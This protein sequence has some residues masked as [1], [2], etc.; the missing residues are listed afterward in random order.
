M[1]YVVFYCILYA[2][3]DNITCNIE[4]ITE[5][6][7]CGR[8]LGLA[9]DTQANNLIIADAYYGLWQVDLSSFKKK[10]LVSPHQELPGKDINRKA[11][12]FNA[13][14]VDRQGSIYW[15]DS[16]SDFPIQDIVFATLANPS[17]R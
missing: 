12:V 13:V 15:T 4:D 10:L 3:N 6:A 5:E 2:F 7:R 1:W 11:K 9:F 17:G 16:S 8:P 14:A